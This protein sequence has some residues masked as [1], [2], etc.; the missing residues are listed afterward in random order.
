MTLYLRLLKYLGSYRIRLAG[1]IVCAAMVA[2][3]SG[4]Y[5]WLVRPVLDGIFISKDS[6][7]LMVLPLVILAV[8][9]LKGLFNYGQNYL[10]NY[11][12]FRVVTDIRQQLFEQMVRLPVSFHDANNSGRLVSRIM[13]S[14]AAIYLSQS[15]RS[16][17]SPIENFQFFDGSSMR[18]RNR[19]F[20]S[21]FETCRKN[22][23][24]SVPLRAR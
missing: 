7:L 9:V 15:F 2:A 23:R 12:G 10:M 20:C 4:V 22:F 16:A 18:S 24:I 11:V 6:T 19:R 5:A 17:T 21:S 3:L 1:A 13:S 8:A 14:Y